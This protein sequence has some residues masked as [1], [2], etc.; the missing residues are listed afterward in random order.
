MMSDLRS[1]ANCRAAFDVFRFLERFVERLV[2]RL[3]DLLL[4]VF[5]DRELLFRRE[6]VELF[7]FVTD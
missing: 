4:A 7:L 2:P 5:F 3:R 1:W 6:E